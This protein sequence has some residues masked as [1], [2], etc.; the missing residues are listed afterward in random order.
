MIHL[1]N[2]T[3]MRSESCIKENGEFW[4]EDFFMA[5][6]VE[7]PVVGRKF[8]AVFVLDTEEQIHFDFFQLLLFFEG[9]VSFFFVFAFFGLFNL[10]FV[11]DRDLAVFVFHLFFEKNTCSEGINIR[12]LITTGNILIAIPFSLPEG[13]IDDGP[14]SG[15]IIRV[16]LD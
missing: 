1:V 6:S 14:A 13:R 12:Q 5:E 3:V 8:S 16:L 15:K 7:E 9:V 2:G 10:Y 11:K 4:V